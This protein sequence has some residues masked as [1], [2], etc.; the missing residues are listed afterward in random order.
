MRRVR[1]DVERE[2]KPTSGT[3]TD[4]QASRLPGPVETAHR[5][6]GNQA[7]Q[8]LAEEDAV[9]HPGDPTER[10]A[11]RVARA[12]VEGD[13]P[14][15]IRMD[16][17]EHTIHRQETDDSE[18]SKGNG[19]EDP[20]A[21]EYRA[22]IRTFG[23]AFMQTEL[24]KRLKREGKELGAEF[25]S[26]VGGK[27]VTL[28]G[29]AGGLTYLGVANRPLPVQPPAFRPDE[30]I[31]GLNVPGLRVHVAYQ[32]PV[33]D[34]T[35]A[36]LGA[37]YQF[38]SESPGSMVPG[39]GDPKLRLDVSA[40]DPFQG[41]LEGMKVML[42]FSFTP[43]KTTDESERDRT[44]ADRLRKD[45]YQFRQSLKTPEERAAERRMLMEMLRE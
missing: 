4:R 34:P 18:Q 37:S 44:E 7:L 9:S 41:G 21:V 38:G 19:K 25:W 35:K 16:V 3:A 8:R 32:G 36:G 30:L 10:E 5:R 31:P 2:R 29:L 23:K 28:T 43:G 39:L 26:T 27:V 13:R 20:Q 15:S 42:K 12:V 45:L 17:G 6:A 11:D 24:G 14:P 40:K 22:A 1:A 33:L